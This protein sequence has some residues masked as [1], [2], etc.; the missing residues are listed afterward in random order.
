[1]DA[2]RRPGRPEV[3]R[4]RGGADIHLGEVV[5]T[6]DEACEWVDVSPEPGAPYAARVCNPPSLVRDP[7]GDVEVAGD[8]YRVDPLGALAETLTGGAPNIHKRRP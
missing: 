8:R 6:S 2:I 1:M 7:A 4:T 5:G 3:I